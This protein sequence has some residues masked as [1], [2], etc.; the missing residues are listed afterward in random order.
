MEKLRKFKPVLASCSQGQKRRG[1]EDGAL[2]VYKHLVKEICD[3]NEVY[4]FDHTQ[5]DSQVGY[6]KLYGICKT[7]NFPLTIGGDHSVSSSSL[8]ASNQ[9]YRDM[10]V[11]WIDAHPDIH[12][13]KS[14]TSGNKHGTPLSVCTGLESMHWT[15]RMTLKLLPFENLTYVG[16]RDIDDFEGQ[17]I[18]DKKIRHLTPSQCVGFIK[19][20]DRPIHIS[21]D[22]DGLDPKYVDS[23]GTKVNDGLHPSEVAS[24]FNEAL[25]Y[26][27]LVSADIVE[28]NEKLGD[29][30]H[31]IN[32]LRE[33]FKD[34]LKDR[35][36]KKGAH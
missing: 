22:V 9:K 19:N 28:F 34:A 8:M 1:V 2:Y 26:D 18:K 33:V 11:I 10:H 36:N 5:F 35:H 25:L 7:L 32:N 15:S 4:K 31:S 27:K 3:T 14:T 12:T 20:L 21:F 29:P 23:T 16:I 17:I 30:V 24:I 13:Y 6:Q